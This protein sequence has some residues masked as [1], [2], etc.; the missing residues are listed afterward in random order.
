MNNIISYFSNSFSSCVWLA[1][2]IVAFLPLCESK[3]AIPLALNTAIWSRAL[4]PL[5]AFVISFIGSSI[6]CL[7]LIFI[8]RKLKNK[9][10]GFIS[11]KFANKYF[12]KANKLNNYTTFRKYLTLCGFASLPLPLTGVWSSSLIAGLTDLKVRYSILAI[13]TGNMI[14]CGLILALCCCFNNSIGNI[15]MISIIL[16]ILFFAVDMVLGGIRKKYKKQEY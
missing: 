13:L 2:L 14:S 6:P 9:T 4:S 1:I 15:C 8:V 10:T 16:V 12:V 5:S 11:S 7:F 3:I